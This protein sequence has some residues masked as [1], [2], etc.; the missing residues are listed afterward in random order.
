MHSLPLLY[1]FLWRHWRNWS[2][3][4]VYHSRVNSG[5]MVSG[6][7]GI[8]YGTGNYGIWIRR[9]SRGTCD[10]G[11]DGPVWTDYEFSDLGEFLQC[12]NFCFSLVSGTTP[13]GGCT[14]GSAYSSGRRSGENSFLFHGRTAAD[15]ETGSSYMA[16]LYTVVDLFL[17]ILPVVSDCLLWLL[18]WHR[19]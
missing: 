4:G 10:A 12:G 1:P 11:S 8:C 16:V 19:R 3:C 6:S 17:Q 2:G 9:A 7:P 15:E 14:S 5:Q 18:L 13:S